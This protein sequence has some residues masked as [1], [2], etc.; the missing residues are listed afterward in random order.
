MITRSKRKSGKSASAILLVASCFVAGPKSLD[1]SSAGTAGSW[2]NLRAVTHDTSYTVVDRRGKCTSGWIGKV[3]A[4]YLILK[5]RNG[6]GA[7]VERKDVIRV[8][9]DHG[10]ATY[11]IYSG[12]SSWVDVKQS[13][14]YHWQ[15]VR[16]IVKP[17]LAEYSGDHI[18][19]S[20]TGVT[21]SQGRDSKNLAKSQISTLDIICLT[22][23]SDLIEFCGEEVGVLCILDPRTWPW[24]LR[25]HSR[26]RV[27]LFDSSL[28]EENTPLPCK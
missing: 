8:T 9:S 16:I 25:I 1:G 27:R 6:M 17:S 23:P 22:P 5:P 12:R 13:N 11:I 20:D 7:K 19:V 26:I 15:A 2:N 10:Y 28:P 3:T 14:Q 21:L 18:N 4:D 24:V